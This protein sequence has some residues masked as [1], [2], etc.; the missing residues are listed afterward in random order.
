ME[1]LESLRAESVIRYSYFVENKL[2]LRS[3]EFG[4]RTR[5]NVVVPKTEPHQVGTAQH[6]H[7]LEIR[8]V[9]GNLV[10][11]CAQFRRITHQEIIVSNDLSIPPSD[12]SNLK[13][14][15]RITIRISQ[16][17][18]AK[19]YWI[20]ALRIVYEIRNTTLWPSL[21]VKASTCTNTITSQQKPS[22]RNLV[23]K[24]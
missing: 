20:P 6:Y 22:L 18:R 12:P 5:N 1:S 16:G 10:A 9:E 24:R 4:Q 13:W 7:V 11:G 15:W 23:N 14:P 2:V 17:W 8:E 3:Q 19:V 21:H